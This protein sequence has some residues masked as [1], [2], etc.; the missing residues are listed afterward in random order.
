M[1]DEPVQ[2]IE[3][4][5]AERGPSEGVAL[6][7]SGGGYRAMLFHV[8]TL[9]R[10]YEAGR[11]RRV[12]RVSSVSG[13]SIAAGVLALAWHRLSFESNRA[14]DD[15]V[16]EV[17]H[18][19]RALA[20]ETIDADAIFWGVALPGRVSDRVAAAYDRYLYRGATLQDLPDAPRFVINATNVQTG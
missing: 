9:W 3:T 12:A 10:L 1:P 13:G 11:L 4:D 18:P 2:S 6:C 5:L 15:F 19:V 8:G 14:G 17:V 16:R 7:L 20:G